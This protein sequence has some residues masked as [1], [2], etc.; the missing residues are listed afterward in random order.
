M[1]AA[2]IPLPELIQLPADLS[3]K[4]R[5]VP[6][7]PERLLRFIRLEVAMNERRQQ[8]HSHEAVA[9]VKRARELVEKRRVEGTTR[10]VAM[11]EFHTNYAEIINAL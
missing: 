3:A 11:Q 6:G 8:R 4:A 1:N 7:L 10:A 5:E 9:L 2:A